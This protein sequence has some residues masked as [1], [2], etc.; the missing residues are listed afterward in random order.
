MRWSFIS[1][2]ME[3]QKVVTTDSVTL[4]PANEIKEP[5]QLETSV[6]DSF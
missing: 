6:P 3:H 2:T 1:G 4:T 5:Y